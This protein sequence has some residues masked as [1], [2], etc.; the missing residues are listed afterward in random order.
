MGAEQPSDLATRLA[1]SL[2][3]VAT[4]SADVPLGAEAEQS[5]F[6]FVEGRVLFRRRR[7]RRLRVTAAV[8]GL[9]LV[10]AGAHWRNTRMRERAE[11]ELTF[12]VAG[13]P[14]LHRGELVPASEADTEV[15]FSDGTRLHM[16]PHARGRVVSLDRQGGRVVLEQGRA[17]VDVRHREN[18]QWRFQAGPFEVQVHGTAFS[19]AW[20]AAT[21][22]FDL[23]ME[24]G[25]VS[26]SGPFE[27]GDRVVRAGESLA[28]EGLAMRATAAADP[29]ARLNAVPHEVSPEPTP[30][31]APRAGAATGTVASP[32][33]GPAASARKPTPARAWQTDLAQ[34][35]AALV[36]ADAERRGLPRVLASADD[37]DLATLADAARFIGKD[38]LA[39]R[40]LLAER[41]RFSG[42]V[43]AAEAAFLL[44]RLEE[45]SDGG[46]TRALAWYDRY[47]KEAP[48]GRYV[49][50]ALGRKMTAL[51]KSDRA[52][53]ALAI[54]SDYLRR[55][56]TGSYAHA[57]AALVERARSS[58]GA[59]LRAP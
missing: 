27:G 59:P 36:V 26:V 41:R 22:R 45:G 37:E 58:A 40:A 56:P 13:G 29:A 5:S 11:E 23:H 6:A 50:E 57:A 7:A 1:E 53:E 49:S 51:Q 12:R 42:S 14:A 4:L 35:R 38:E 39:R 52:P 15:A 33:T 30:P 44:G 9:C 20:D 10:A 54:A 17:H 34:G 2:G 3:R 55:F 16:A 28:F 31:S 47:L 43:R 18:A 46:A 21:Q 25:V 8:A 48:N 24:N 19:M 32:A